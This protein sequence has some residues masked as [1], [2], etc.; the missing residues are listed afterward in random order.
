M[1]LT[2]ASLSPHTSANNNDNVPVDSSSSSSNDNV[3]SFYYNGGELV[4]GN[5]ER[6][7]VS[8]GAVTAT[9]DA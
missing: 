8:P 9:A 2:W 5:G 6:L 3:A 4:G 7:L 1:P